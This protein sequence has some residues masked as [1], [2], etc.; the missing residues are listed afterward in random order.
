LED[1]SADSEEAE[2]NDLYEETADNDVLAHGRVCH[3]FDHDSG[4]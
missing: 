2:E 3:I 1:D 4:S